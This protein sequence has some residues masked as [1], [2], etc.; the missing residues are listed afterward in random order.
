MNVESPVSLAIGILAGTL[1]LSG[2][3]LACGEKGIEIVDS[4]E[5]GYVME[6]SA[7]TRSYFPSNGEKFLL[8]KSRIKVTEHQARHI[9]D[10]YLRME[11]GKGAKITS[12]DTQIPGHENHGHGHGNPQLS[13]G[14]YTWS[15]N[16]VVPGMM[17]GKAFPM[18][19][20][21]ES[22]DVYGIGCGLGAGSVVYSPDLS[23]YPD[24]DYSD[25]EYHM[26]SLPSLQNAG[27]IK[28]TGMG[29]LDSLTAFFISLFG[30]V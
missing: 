20:D 2:V 21:M 28:M 26:P 29:I 1:F 4:L 22:G 5:E 12:G 30:F 8:E 7:C 16:V 15:F 10:D 6:K 24:S 3:S 14:H 27:K 17:E 9:L 25:A 23:E 18:Y 19:V 13:H 11:Y